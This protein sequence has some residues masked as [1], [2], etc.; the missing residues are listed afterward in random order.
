MT[1]R[2]GES[3]GRRL[4]VVSCEFDA[5]R[6][7]Q[8]MR[9][10]RLAEALARSGWQVDVLAFPPVTP[11]QQSTMVVHSAF[12]GPY[13][14]L[15]GSRAGT[16]EGAT[17]ALSHL[18][19][20]EALPS[21][22]WKGLAD[23]RIRRLASCAMFPDYRR[24]GLFWLRRAARLMIGRH[25]YAAAVLSHEPA[26]ALELQPLLRRAGIP[27]VADLGDPVEAAY[28][29]RRWRRRAR[30]LEART[31]ESAAAVVV[32]SERT[33]ALMQIRHGLPDQRLHVIT[34]GFEELHRGGIARGDRLRVA[35]TGRV[36]PF[37]NPIRVLE[38]LTD[39]TGI[40]L[41][42]AVPDPPEWFAKLLPR[43][44]V[45]LHGH[46]SQ[47]A[48]VALQCDV[49]VLLLVGN[50][51]ATQVPGKLYEYLG[52]ARP[53]L[54]VAQDSEDEGGSLVKTLHRG[55]VVRDDANEI[56]DAL[57]RLRE[58]KCADALASAFDLREECVAPYSW[59]ALAARYG[60]ILANIAAP[61]RP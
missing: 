37:R 43:P 56:G 35:Y 10:V 38:A 2:A 49:D 59:K 41:E 15:L 50:A 58:L 20:A 51:D 48:A 34:Q 22:N 23:A 8:G 7:P 24:E 44:G 40:Q 52:S 3:V 45:R 13:Q 18:E 19:D 12:P 1:D 55:W 32:T 47:P 9:W 60:E 31:C 46:L 61:F 39:K 17:A 25:R 5:D 57:V 29:P 21:L 53:I 27:F 4:L 28:T 26:L 42:L 11:A 14:A 30:A 36:Y 54:Y 6:S 16:R 33:R